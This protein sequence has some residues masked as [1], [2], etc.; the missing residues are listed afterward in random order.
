MFFYVGSGLNHYPIRDGVPEINAGRDNWRSP[1]NPAVGLEAQS[2]AGC[3]VGFC[4]VGYVVFGQVL[5]RGVGVSETCQKTLLWVLLPVNGPRNF[6]TSFRLEQTSHCLLYEGVTR[7]PRTAVDFSH[8]CL[9]NTCCSISG[10]LYCLKQDRINHHI[11]SRTPERY[12]SG[13]RGPSVQ[14]WQTLPPFH[15]FWSHSSEPCECRGS[16]ARGGRCVGRCHGE[17]T[18][19]DHHRLDSPQSANC[20]HIGC[21]RLIR[22]YVCVYMRSGCYIVSTA[23]GLAWPSRSRT[24]LGHARGM[25][26]W[27]GHEHVRAS[28]TESANGYSNTTPWSNK[29]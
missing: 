5:C 16:A 24:A 14:A 2:V 19:S 18:R 22:M 9:E 7:L 12:S 26:G 17:E 23:Q 4:V 25:Q 29:G 27:A 15:T 10:G 8:V 21:S 6:G 13:N 11:A 20:K 3:G 28:P 1:S